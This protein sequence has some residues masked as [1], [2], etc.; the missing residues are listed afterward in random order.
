MAGCVHVC[1][2]PGILRELEPD[3]VSRCGLLRDL[4]GIYGTAELPFTSEEFMVWQDFAVG[5]QTVSLPQACVL[6]KVWALGFQ[7]KGF[8][9]QPNKAKH[10]T[11]C[12]LHA[13]VA[14]FLQDS[15]TARWA[16]LVG[17]LLTTW[18]CSSSVQRQK[19]FKLWTATINS[20]QQSLPD[21]LMFQVC[22]LQP[23]H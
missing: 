19:D 9:L 12:I 2:P 18:C 14:G 16:K 22:A 13:Q 1:Y 20:F 6:L 23:S 10:S 3:V 7:H 5:D 21:E 11:H 17:N 15:M 8:P 4:S